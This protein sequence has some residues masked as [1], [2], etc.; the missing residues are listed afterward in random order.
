MNWFFEDITIVEE[1]SLFAGISDEFSNEVLALLLHCFF[2]LLP[3]LLM[4]NNP[5]TSSFY[6]P[7]T[8]MILTS[9]P[10][11]LIQQPGPSQISGFAMRINKVQR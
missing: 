7:V 10:V 4:A 1:A 11:E 3:F 6:F 8:S 9:W 5:G 2:A